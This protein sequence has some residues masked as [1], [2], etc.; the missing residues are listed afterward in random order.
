MADII[1][2]TTFIPSD[3]T[4]NA[5]YSTNNGDFNTNFGSDLG[6]VLRPA[7]ETRLGGIKVGE[8]LLVTEDGTLSVNV[9]EDVEDTRRPITSKAVVD[10]VGVGDEPITNLEIDKILG[11]I[12]N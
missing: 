12:D 10:Y 7:T 1:F 3:S 2:E 9:T 4:F 8:N 11:L 5:E 6:S